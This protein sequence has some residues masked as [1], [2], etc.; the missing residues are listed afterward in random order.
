[1]RAVFNSVLLVGLAL[2]AH[3]APPSQRQVLKYEP[4]VVQLA[5]TMI[6]AEGRTDGD[7]KITFPALAL[8]AAVQIE[9]APDDDLNVFEDNVSVVQLVLIDPAQMQQYRSLLGRPVVVTGTLFH[10]H[11]GHHHTKVLINV[12]KIAR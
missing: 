11:T 2:T 7:E 10:A 3:A 5:G 8:K 6:A 9:A 1:M 4:A 12:Q